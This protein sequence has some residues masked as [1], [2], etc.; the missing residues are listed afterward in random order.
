MK[1]NSATCNSSGDYFIVTS[2][3]C[4]VNEASPFFV[5]NVIKKSSAVFGG[6]SLCKGVEA[7]FVS[8][9]E[10]NKNQEPA[11]SIQNNNHG[12]I[13]ASAGDIITFKTNEYD[14]TPGYQS[15]TY[16]YCGKPVMSMKYKDEDQFSVMITHPLTL[17][18]AFSFC[19]AFMS[20]EKLL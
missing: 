1:A 20:I 13:D 6:R 18:Q 4:E 8:K 5:G 15:I 2:N 19:L 9:I 7:E 16:S 12:I 10:W 11:F 17:F 3:S 14:A